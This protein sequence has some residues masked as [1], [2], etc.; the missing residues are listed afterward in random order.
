MEIPLC[1]MISMQVER[2]AL[3]NDILK[4]QGDFYFNFYLEMQYFMFLLKGLMVAL[5]M[6]A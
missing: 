5:L 6:L 1:C 4:L 2:L 3:M